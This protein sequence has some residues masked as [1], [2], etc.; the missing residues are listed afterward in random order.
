CCLASAC[1]TK[2]RTRPTKNWT[3]ATSTAASLRRRFCIRRLQ[4]GRGARGWKSENALAPGPQPQ[5]RL[6]Q[7]RDETR[8]PDW[9]APDVLRCAADTA[10]GPVHAVRL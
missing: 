4:T 10:A 5:P 2:T 9:L 8:V 1:R 7:C 6:R 3:W